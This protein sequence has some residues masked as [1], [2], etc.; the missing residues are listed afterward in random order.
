M[1]NGLDLVV[2]GGRHYGQ[3]RIYENDEQRAGDL[4]RIQLERRVCFG[5]LNDLHVT[6]R[7]ATLA[8]DGTGGAA[9]T[10]SLWAQTFGVPVIPVVSDV[11]KYGV[12]AQVQR[13]KSIVEALLELKK[14]GREVLIVSFPGSDFE[15]EAMAKAH[16]LEVL[17]VELQTKSAEEVKS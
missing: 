3:E 6:Q 1:S 16:G 2:C 10:S 12:K 4:P 17:E 5:T 9:E 13:R 14:E 7:V 15:L 11:R 8:T